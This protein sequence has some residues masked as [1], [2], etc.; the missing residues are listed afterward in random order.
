MSTTNLNKTT[1]TIE[2]I[3]SLTY[4]VT[5]ES[6]TST[7]YQLTHEEICRLLLESQAAFLNGAEEKSKYT[8]EELC[9]GCLNRVI[10]KNPCRDCKKG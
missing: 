7:L 10:T 4:K 6:P 3:G 2:T 9:K 8:Q 5:R 1:Q